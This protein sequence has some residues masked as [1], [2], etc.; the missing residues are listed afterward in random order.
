MGVKL[1]LLILLAIGVLFIV[2]CAS[3]TQE[4]PAAPKLYIVEEPH[5]K[6][7]VVG[8]KSPL[9][10]VEETKSTRNGLNSARA[11][12]EDNDTQK[13]FELKSKLKNAVRTVDGKLIVGYDEELDNTRWKEVES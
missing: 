12:R 7:F 9:V 11:L 8:G 1:I 5:A 6:I 3:E 2:S 4:K 10:W 13:E